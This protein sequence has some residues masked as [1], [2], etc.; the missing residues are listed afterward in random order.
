[1]IVILAAGTNVLASLALY[2]LAISLGISLSAV[3]AIALVPVALFATLLPISV[4]GW[5]VRESVLVFLLGF[6]AVP[7][8]QALV[9]SL[10]FGAAMT[11]SALP[12]GLIWVRLRE[13]I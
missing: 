4:A 5:G 11:L 2:F 6:V 8:D 9:L 10:C 12:G 3:D 7:P 1:L 13:G